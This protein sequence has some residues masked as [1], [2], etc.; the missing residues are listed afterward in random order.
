MMI[1]KF[2]DLFKKQSEDMVNGNLED[3]NNNF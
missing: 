1:K 3:K 2:E